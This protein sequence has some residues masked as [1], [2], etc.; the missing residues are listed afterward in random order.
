M[1]AVEVG[2]AHGRGPG[3]RHASERALAL[4]ALAGVEQDQLVVPAQ[5]V[6]VVGPVPGWKLACGAQN[7]QFA[8]AHGDAP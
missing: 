2:D 3:D 7:H 4:C 1:V 5:R 8:C 6:A